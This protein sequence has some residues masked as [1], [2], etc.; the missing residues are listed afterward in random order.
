MNNTYNADNKDAQFDLFEVAYKTVDEVI[1]K[2]PSDNDALATL[3]TAA[4]MLAY[5]MSYD[6]PEI[7]ALVRDNF[8]VVYANADS[9]THDAPEVLQ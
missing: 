7:L 6:L 9:D 2:A 3:V 8:T 5:E 4:A 1:E